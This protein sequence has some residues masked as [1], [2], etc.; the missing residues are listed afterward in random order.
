MEEIGN[1]S[2]V[3]SSKNTSAEGRKEAE[4][5]GGDDVENIMDPLTDRAD[6]MFMGNGA[7]GNLPL[8]NLNCYPMRICL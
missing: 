8:F 7:A 6:V 2:N 5:Q 3:S 4:G 1:K